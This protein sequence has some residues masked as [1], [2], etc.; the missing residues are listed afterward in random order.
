M[1]EN[2]LKYIGVSGWRSGSVVEYIWFLQW[3]QVGFP[4]PTLGSPQL[5]VNPS[6]IWHPSDL[7]THTHTHT[8]LNCVCVSLWDPKLRK[9][10]LSY[11]SFVL[12]AYNSFIIIG[13][14]SC[15]YVFWILKCFQKLRNSLGFHFIVWGSVPLKIMFVVFLHIIIV[16]GKELL[17]WS[18]TPNVKI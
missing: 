3:T 15:W 16:F 18:S 17:H 12:K 13:I 9:S 8:L 14:F 4:S 1:R 7:Y 11:L 2:Y 10:L 6:G 5:S